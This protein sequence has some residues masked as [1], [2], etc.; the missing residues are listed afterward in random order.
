MLTLLPHAAPS[1]TR[2]TKS[3]HINSCTGSK[4]DLVNSSS[5]TISSFPYRYLEAILQQNISTSKT[6]KT[7]SNYE[8]FWWFGW[9]FNASLG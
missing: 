5:N 1:I 3:T 6:G 8:D 7:C 9:I 2:V 4:L